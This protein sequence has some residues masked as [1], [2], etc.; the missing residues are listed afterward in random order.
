MIENKRACEEI[1]T[2]KN[3]ST[4]T[5]ITTMFA[6]PCFIVICA[7]MTGKKETFMSVLI[8]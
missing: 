6:H 3:V 8:L 7:E 1:V 2:L 5:T 4:V